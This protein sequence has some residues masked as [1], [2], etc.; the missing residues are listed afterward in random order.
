MVVL[1]AFQSEKKLNRHDKAL[2]VKT[3]INIWWLHTHT[4]LTCDSVIQG[5]KSAKLISWFDFKTFAVYHSKSSQNS[6]H[7]MFERHKVMSSTQVLFLVTSSFT[8]MNV[9]LLV[10]GEFRGLCDVM[11]HQIRAEWSFKVLS[12]Q[13]L[14]NF[15]RVKSENL[16][17]FLEF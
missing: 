5:E 7:F 4:H 8:V 13:D 2:C 3:T 12:Q 14:K 9:L 17:S 1:S 11:F 10:L 6:R 16:Q 15:Q